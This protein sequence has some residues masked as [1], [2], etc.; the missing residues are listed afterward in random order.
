MN[1]KFFDLKK[2][3]QDRMINAALKVFAKNG[4]R[5]ASTDDMVREAAISKG[6]LFH[7]FGSKLGLYTFVYDYSV[8]YMTLELGTV[9]DPKETDLFEL[10]KQT[11]DAKLHAMRGY[12]YMQQFLNRSMQ[13]D[14]NEA[15]L[16]IAEKRNML[17]ETYD[18]IYK[19]ADSAKLPKGADMGM[20]R[21]ML[22]LTADGLMTERFYDASFQPEMLYE[23]IVSYLDMMKKIME[24]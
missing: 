3:K 10:M 9:V 6:L 8:R 11:A 22:E 12:P 24:R 23:E 16:A 13:E 14:V 2:E 19:Q 1:G 5:H 20:L 4:Y 7:Y 15:L 21:K 18:N 17:N